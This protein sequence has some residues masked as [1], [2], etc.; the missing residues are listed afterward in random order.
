MTPGS[1]SL[2]DGNTLKVGVNDAI[3]TQEI[4]DTSDIKPTN[5]GFLDIKI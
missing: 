3:Y 1:Q 4:P 5:G 2:S